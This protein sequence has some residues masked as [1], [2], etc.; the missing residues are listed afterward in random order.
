MMVKERKKVLTGRVWLQPTRSHTHDT[1][2]R[3]S[4]GKT[5]TEKMP[6]GKRRIILPLDNDTHTH[7]E[8]RNTQPLCPFPHTRFFFLSV[9]ILII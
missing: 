7:T 6:N 2:K 9:V 8:K 3:S 5:T 1:N 4:S